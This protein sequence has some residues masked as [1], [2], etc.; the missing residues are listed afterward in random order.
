M[1]FA[2]SSSDRQASN[3]CREPQI[4]P[5]LFQTAATSALLY[6]NLQNAQKRQ[7]SASVQHHQT[8]RR[9]QLEM[10]S[11]SKQFSEATHADTQF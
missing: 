1:G 3:S 5:L 2:S 6:F 10:S 9:R 8:R 7:D 11:P 4:A